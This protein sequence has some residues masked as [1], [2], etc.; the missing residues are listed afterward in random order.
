MNKKVIQTLFTILL[1]TLA[2]CQSQNLTSLEQRAQDIFQRLRQDKTSPL[3]ASGTIQADEIRIAAELGGQIIAIEVQKGDPVKMGDVLVRLDDALLLNKL[4]EAEA[5]VAVAQANL[6]QVRAGPR[7]EAVA[8]QQ[9]LLT[10]AQAKRD[11][12]WATWNNA[13]NAVHNPQELDAQITEAQT[14]VRLAEQGVALAQAELAKQQLIRDQKRPD[15]PERQ[16]ADRQVIAAQEQLAAAQADLAAAQ[17]LLEQLQAIRRRPL[18]LIVQANLAQGQYQIAEAGVAVAQAQLDDLLAGPTAEEIAVAEQQVRLKEA[19]LH[20]IR[21]Q[22]D[23]FTLTSP[24]DGIVLDRV[25]QVGELAAPAATILTLADL[26]NVTL[27]VYI[28]VNRLG[29]IHLG[30]Q[31]HV[32]VDSFPGRT[33]NGQVTYI[34]SQ[35]EYT[36]RNIAT[37]EERL[38]TFY[39]VKIQLPNADGQLKPGM[40][41]DA[42]FQ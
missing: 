39:A 10:L 17:T 21:V 20:A 12:A 30:Q 35:A 2:G 11:S 24:I 7:P 6:T 40:P 1:A 22:Q 19:Q 29:Q 33:F 34:S 26:R 38:N 18:G 15:S 25:L 13:L 9:A 28:P 4:Q 27:T 37:Q 5:A 42:T 8:A 16:A 14:Q 41:A 32:H 36:P 23:K 31:V 3:T